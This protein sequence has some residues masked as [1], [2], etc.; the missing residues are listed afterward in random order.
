MSAIPSLP[1]INPT[2]LTPDDFPDLE[3]I[4]TK[5]KARVA[6][7]IENADDIDGLDLSRMVIHD[8]WGNLVH[9][10]GEVSLLLPG[11][12]RNKYAQR[13]LAV[14]QQMLTDGKQF[15]VARGWKA[16][17]LPFIAEHEEFTVTVF[18]RQQA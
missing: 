5:A 15:Q 6:N 11:S 3:I 8:E 17:I 12:I 14:W 2:N 16:A 9:T 7:H 1:S 4:L 18:I 13:Q 10:K